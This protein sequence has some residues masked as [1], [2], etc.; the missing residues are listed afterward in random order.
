MSSLGVGLMSGT[1]LDGIDAALVRFTGDEPQVELV[2]FHFVPYATADRERLLQMIVRGST[3]DLALLHVDLGARF[4][5]AVAGLIEKAAPGKGIDFVAMHG[6]TVWHE[7][8]VVSFQLGD[9]A[10][11]AERLGVQVISDFRA[12]DVAAG[13]Q[14][15]PLVPI[16]DALLFG[17][18][19]GP[20]ALLNIGGM[21][22]V[23][24]VPQHGATDGVIAFDTGPGMALIDGVVR[25][26]EP[27]VD[28]DEGGCLA[29]LG[30]PVE[31]VVEGVL[32]DPWFDQPPP[33]S[34]GRERFGEALALDVVDAVRS[35][36]QNASANDCIATAVAITAR[37]IVEQTGRWLPGGWE[38]DVLVSG[39]G[40]R[41]EALVRALRVGMPDRSLQPFGSVF[42]DGD[43][44][45]AVAFA[46]LGWLTLH[47]HAGNVPSATGAAGPRV[48]GRI[49]PV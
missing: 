39:G 7:P 18:K 21:A 4:A 33:K 25:C 2:A 29:A 15:A 8:S 32:T 45:E 44:K 12:R 26:V 16:A 11:L 1:S 49:T 19:D 5:D 13:G 40:V 35:V 17:R 9:P 23:T 27:G 38:G 42:F 20:R 34:T 48:L 36:R 43:A 10:L 22:N 47:G 30:Q 24:W 28:F 31:S 3:R 14:G 41:N 46:L 37:S 6:Q